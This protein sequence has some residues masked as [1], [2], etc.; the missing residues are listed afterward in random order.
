MHEYKVK[1][2]KDLIPYANNSRTH[3]DEQINQVAS[4]IKEFGFTNPVLIDEQGGIIAGHGRVLA[5]K[6][7][8]LDDIPCIELRGL[9]DAQKK[10]YV[11]ADNQLALNSGWDV[12]MLRLEIES[13]QELDFDIDLLGFDDAFINDLFDDDGELYIESKLGLKDKYGQPPFSIFNARDGGWQKRKQY[14]QS[15][16]IQ[17]ELGRDAASNAK[18]S[19]FKNSKSAE[20]KILNQAVSI[21]DPVLCEIGYEWFSPKGGLILDPFAGGSVRGIVAAECGREYIGN[22]LSQD[23]IIANTKQAHDICKEIM[24]VWTNGDSLEIK[25]LVGDIQA[26]LLF[27]CPPYAN[28]EVYSDKPEDISNMDY[29]GF[30]E[31]YRKIIAECYDLLKD[32]SFAVWTIG[33][34]RDKKGNY[35]NF[36]GDTITAFKDAGF[37]YYNEAILVTM[38]G[39]TSLT[40][41]RNFPIG[42]KLGKTHQ[43]V[44]VFVKGDG[45]KAAKRCGDI[46]IHIDET[47]DSDQ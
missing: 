16:G 7:L 26:D 44:L 2:I 29:T 43:N 31:I 40:T 10:A 34:V 19:T 1:K 21:F 36:V 23:Q 41:S 25:K 9:T 45:K 3:S 17:S 8:S 18:G 15:I 30:M 38:V 28:L 37:N 42:R 11:I 20:S 14:W 39:N 4:S 13:L 6:K 32:N 33:E 47:I 24:P 22:D 46:E 35:L 12:D 5:A 27:S